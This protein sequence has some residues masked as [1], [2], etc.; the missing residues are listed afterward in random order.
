MENSV[1]SIKAMTNNR[2][3]GLGGVLFERSHKGH[4]VLLCLEATMTHLGAGI[5]ELELDLFKG[6]P[7]GVNKEG[8]SQSEYTLLGSDT[9]SLNH[10]KVLLHQTIMRESTHGVDGLVGQVIVGGSIVLDKLA[11]LHVESIT[12]VIDLFVNLGT[13]MVTLLTSTR[14]S[15]LDTTG[16]P[17]SD[18]SDLTET[19]MGLA[20]QLLG[21]PAR[22]DSL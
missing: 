4:F 21:M 10:D 16:M 20:R 17:G 8:L 11:I 1:F 12:D 3:L 14:N 19:F 2:S 22:S 7:L 13:V 18:T 6:L 15:V 9:A 5:D